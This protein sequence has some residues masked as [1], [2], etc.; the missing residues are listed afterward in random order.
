MKHLIRFIT[1]YIVSIAVFAG[2][3]FPLVETIDSLI[4]V[5]IASSGAV[6]AMVLTDSFMYKK[7]A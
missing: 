7:L 5:A 4:A 6:I 2:L 1:A 3:L